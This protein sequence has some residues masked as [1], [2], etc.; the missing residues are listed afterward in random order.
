MGSTF[1]AIGQSPTRNA[2]VSEIRRDCKGLPD[3]KSHHSLMP[4][5]GILIP[6]LNRIASDRTISQAGWTATGH[7]VVR[8]CRL[9]HAGIPA[10]DADHLRSVQRL[11]AESRPL[12][13]QGFTRKIEN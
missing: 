2:L 4:L 10:V 6:F 5:T 9:S 13:G 1:R 7:A 12:P 11:P 3:C 8:R